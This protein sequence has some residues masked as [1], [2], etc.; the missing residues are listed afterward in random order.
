MATS[1]FAGIAT[2]MSVEATI[3]MPIVFLLIMARVL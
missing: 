3:A 2:A 1:A